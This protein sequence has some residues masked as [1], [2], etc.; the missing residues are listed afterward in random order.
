MTY[1]AIILGA[2]GN[3]G[4]CISKACELEGWP[5]MGGTGDVKL[6]ECAYQ[7]KVIIFDC[8]KPGH[9]GWAENSWQNNFLAVRRATE[10]IDAA[11]RSVN[12]AAVMLCST[13]WVS[14]RS[15]PYSETKFLLENIA[16]SHNRYGAFP[17]VVDRIGMQNDAH[18]DASRFE[19]SVRNLPGE[20]G[21]RVVASVLLAIDEFEG[22]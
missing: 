12:V 11:N 7:G 14:V 9:V 22:R 1:T 8:G 20:L 2:D 16:R 4:R 3:V 13:P 18:V 21:E 5:I 19:E 17:V 15:D 6:L 10:I